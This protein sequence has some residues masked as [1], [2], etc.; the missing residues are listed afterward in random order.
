MD[1]LLL[2]LNENQTDR[3]R[4]IAEKR[5]KTPAVPRFWNGYADN[6]ECSWIC[7]PRSNLIGVLV[8][9]TVTRRGA[10]FAVGEL[11]K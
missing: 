2:L 9:M 11:S 8:P 10:G 4:K 1:C 5:E 7:K 3:G 6:A